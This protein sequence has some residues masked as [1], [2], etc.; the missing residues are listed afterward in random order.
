MNVMTT[1]IYTVIKM[2]PCSADSVQVFTSRNIERLIHKVLED[3]RTMDFTQS[4]LKVIETKLRA[5]EEV[6]ENDT[7][8]NYWCYRLSQDEDEDDNGTSVGFF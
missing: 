2:D 3:A 8:T 5:G 6:L 4:D 7:S 1:T